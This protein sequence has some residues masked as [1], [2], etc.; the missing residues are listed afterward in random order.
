MEI[1]KLN[2]DLASTSGCHPH[3]KS[4][5]LVAQFLLALAI[6][7]WDIAGPGL[8]GGTRSAANE[9]LALHFYTVSAPFDGSYLY[10]LKALVLSQDSGW[11]PLFVYGLLKATRR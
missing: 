4:C 11:A 7:P 9:K 6:K 2:E 1:E 8:L 3:T 5:Q 10:I